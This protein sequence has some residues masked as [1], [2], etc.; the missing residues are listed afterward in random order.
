MNPVNNAQDLLKKHK[1]HK[2]VLK[3]KMKTQTQTQFQH[4]PNE[5][6]E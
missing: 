3:K 4:Y 5:Y 6:L 2:N 1:N